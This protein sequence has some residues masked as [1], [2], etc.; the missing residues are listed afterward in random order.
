ME[1]IIFIVKYI[2][3]WAVPLGMI[4]AQFA[5]IYWLKSSRKLSYLFVIGTSLSFFLNVFYFWI[6]GPQKAVEFL[7]NQ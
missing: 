1:L 6:G 7:F 4:S 2:P 5:Y 3:F